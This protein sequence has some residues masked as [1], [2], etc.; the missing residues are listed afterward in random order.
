VVLKIK[1]ERKI[2]FLAIDCGNTNVVFAIFRDDGTHTTW[3]CHSDATRTA[4]EYASWL[5]PLMDHADIQFDDIKTALISSVVPDANFNLKKLCDKYCGITPRFIKEAGVKIDLNIKLPHPETLGADR[6]VNAIAAK[7]KYQMPCVIIDFGT[8]TTFDVI[9]ETG[10]YIG[11][12]IS[13]GVNLSVDAL[14]RAAAALPKISVEKT[15]HVIGNTTITAMQSGLYWG[16]VTMIEGMIAKISAELG[17][18]PT[19]IATGG[20]AVTIADGT[21]IVDHVDGDLTLDGLRIIQSI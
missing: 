11:G 10:A 19:V 1:R 3:R 7:Q 16:Y 20:L 2:M 9:D 8:A 18:N 15:D 12:V 21:D 4:D 13:P 5:M 14:Y 17:V 6:I